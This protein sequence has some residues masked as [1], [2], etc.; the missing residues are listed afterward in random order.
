MKKKSFFKKLWRFLIDNYFISIFF[1]CI[2]FVGV[3]SV[4]KLFFV[5]PTYVYVKVKMGQGLWWASTQKPSMW[6]IES[7]KKAKNETEND[8][9][10]QPQAQI[11]SFRYYPTYI[12]NQ[13][14]VYL[15]MK[16]KVSKLGKTSKYNFKRSAIGVGS[17][18]DFEFP[19]LQFSATIIEISEK[20]IKEK[21]KEK[22]IYI[23]KPYGLFSE[24]ENIKIGDKYFDGEDNVVEVLDKLKGEPIDINIPYKSTID[25]NLTQTRQGITVKLRIKTTEDDNKIIFAEEQNISVGKTIYIATNTFQFQDYLVAKIE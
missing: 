4:Y 23:Y 19:S 18:V 24:F 2:V 1:A 16:L 25:P 22:I 14:D 6:F 21:L 5:K 15:I 3:V 12:Q 8:L 17:P 13:Y 9:T 20:P 11:L 10:G 7:I